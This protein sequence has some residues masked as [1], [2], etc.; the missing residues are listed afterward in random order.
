MGRGDTPAIAIRPIGVGIGPIH[1]IA[2]AIRKD[3]DAKKINLLEAIVAGV[4]SS[5]K[6]PLM[7]GGVG[8]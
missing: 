1:G 5:V 4:Q 8:G 6:W 3:N 2:I 7:T